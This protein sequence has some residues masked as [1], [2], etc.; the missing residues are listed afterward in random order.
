M[1]RYWKVLEC[2]EA[3]ALLVGGEEQFNGWLPFFLSLNCLVCSLVWLV[4][5]VHFATI[6]LTVYSSRIEIYPPAPDC[7]KVPHM[8]QVITAQIYP[9]LL[10]E[11][12]NRIYQLTLSLLSLICSAR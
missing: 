3:V 6:S 8:P 12:I 5:L 1:R 7:I 4:R 10:D 9:Q 11:K 2:G